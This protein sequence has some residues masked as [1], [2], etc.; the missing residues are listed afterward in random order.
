MIDAWDGIEEFAAVCEAGSFTGASNTFGASVTHMSRAVARLEAKLQ[1]QLL[2]RTTRS[3]RLTEIGQTFYDRCQRLVEDRDEAFSAI[4]AGGEPQGN[5]RVTCSYTL[6]ERF[7]GPLLRTFAMAWPALSVTLDL[8]NGV[9]DLIRDDFDLAIRTGHLSDSRLI[10]KRIAAREVATVAAPAYLERRGRPKT[11]A[12]LKQHD[13]MTGSSKHWQFA[14]GER[15]RAKGRWRCNS[16]T[17]VLEAAIAGI[18]ICQVPAFYIGDKVQLGLLELLL[19]SYRPD[20]EPI[21]AVYPHR[22][23]ISPKVGLAIEFL[24]EH[25]QASLD[26]QASQ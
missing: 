4:L 1:V 16:G 2:H 21:W 9:K 3:L 23:H 11:I 8:D 18:G 14:N 22:R 10:A 24:Q 26:G 15:F 7:V 19:E 5:L 6:G 17:S 13:C 12:D 20:A 25:L